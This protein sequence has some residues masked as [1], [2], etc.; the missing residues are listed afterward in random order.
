MF[1]V[2]LARLWH[3]RAMAQC[4]AGRG[5]VVV[6]VHFS[7]S[8]LFLFVVEQASGQIR[9]SAERP[10]L[11]RPGLPWSFSVCFPYL[12][13][14]LGLAM[15]CVAGSVRVSVWMGQLRAGGQA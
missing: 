15:S 11:V 10:A 1:S 6:A 9:S 14:W 7:L 13:L 3:G 8:I 5:G 12:L 2:S 4:A